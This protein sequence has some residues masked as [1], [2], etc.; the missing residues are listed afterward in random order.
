MAN[1]IAY[2]LVELAKEYQCKEIHI[3]TLSWLKSTGKKWNHSEIFQK[4]EEVATLEGIKVVKV[5]AYNSS[6]EH[7]ITKEIGEVKNRKIQ[8]VNGKYI[9]RDLL[10][11]INLALR[12]KKKKETNKIKEIKILQKKRKRLSKSRKKEILDTIN[13]KSGV[14]IVAFRP[15]KVV[16]F[17]PT[18]WQNKNVRVVYTSCLTRNK[19]VTNRYKGIYL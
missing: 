5:D 16:E 9:D 19:T 17:S 1:Q 8:F 3:E 13:K 2:E 6:K 14:Q 7:P 12:N 15:S 10:A 4:I 11:S 18:T